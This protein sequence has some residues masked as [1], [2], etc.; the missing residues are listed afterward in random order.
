MD[1][2][3]EKILWSTCMGSIS[4]KIQVL[5]VTSRH[6]KRQKWL[7]GMGSFSTLPIFYTYTI[8]TRTKYQ[9]LFN[10]KACECKALQMI[11]ISNLQR[12]LAAKHTHPS[13]GREITLPHALKGIHSRQTYHGLY[14]DTTYRQS[15]TLQARL[16]LP[17][18]ASSL[19]TPIYGRLCRFCWCM[20]SSQRVG[21]VALIQCDL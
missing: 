9:V 16:Q 15:P 12:L 8:Y 10:C 2:I 6:L 17:Q 20:F 14:Q 4:S 1:T 7:S 18:D 13:T 21:R 19:P 3:R 5:L 11:R